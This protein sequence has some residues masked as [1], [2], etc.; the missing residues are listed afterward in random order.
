MPEYPNH[1]DG[2]SLRRGAA[3]RS[4]L[5]QPMEVDFMVDVHSAESGDRV[6]AAAQEPS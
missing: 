6:A 5:S 1:S 2:D 3:D 4:D